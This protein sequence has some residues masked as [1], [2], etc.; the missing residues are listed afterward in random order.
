MQLRDPK[1]ICVSE[2]QIV[3]HE[4]AQFYHVCK[5]DIGEDEMIPLVQYKR[6]APRIERYYTEPFIRVSPSTKMLYIKAG[7]IKEIARLYSSDIATV[8]QIQV[9]SRLNIETTR[10]LWHNRLGHIND[11][12]LSSLHKKTVGVPQITPQIGRAH[13]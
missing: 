2:G 9:R 7:T 5:Y 6:K 10:I 12:A 8:P 13:V 1:R 3:A 11:D 4:D